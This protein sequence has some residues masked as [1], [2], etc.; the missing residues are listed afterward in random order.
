MLGNSD[1]HF[2]FISVPVNIF[3]SNFVNV[4]VKIK[5][6]VTAVY[7]TITCLLQIELIWFGMIGHFKQI[8]TLIFFFLKSYFRT[9]K[10]KSL[11]KYLQTKSPHIHSV[12]NNADDLKDIFYS[13]KSPLNSI[14]SL[15]RSTNVFIDTFLSSKVLSSWSYVFASK[16]TTYK[17]AATSS[18]IPFLCGKTKDFHH[19][20]LFFRINLR[21]LFQQN[22]L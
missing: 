9:V 14:W 12:F 13:K 10:N 15:V 17:T 11:K 21:N 6:N 20:M 8:S 22:T 7:I 1:F 18:R 3:F 2:F 4:Y 19:L 5:K 16:Q